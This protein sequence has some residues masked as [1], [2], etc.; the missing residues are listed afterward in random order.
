MYAWWP[1][2]ASGGQWWPVVASVTLQQHMWLPT[3]FHPFEVQKRHI[4]PWLSP[5]DR[6]IN[7]SITDSQI[8]GDFV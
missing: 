1:V 5:Y 8:K 4:S 7:E 3:S 2:V 6:F